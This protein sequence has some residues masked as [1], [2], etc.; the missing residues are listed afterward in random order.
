MFTAD[1]KPSDDDPRE[2]GPRLGDERGTLVESLRRQ[3]LTLVMKCSIMGRGRQR[4]KRVQSS[5]LS[6]WRGGST[7]M[8]YSRPKSS[9]SR[10]SGNMPCSSGNW[11]R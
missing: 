10:K 4:M 6:T 1:G 8:K 5:S 11:L 2:N 9:L 3:R 7:W